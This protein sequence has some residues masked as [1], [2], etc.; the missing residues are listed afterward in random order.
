MGGSADS[1]TNRCPGCGL[2]LDDRDAPPP[3]RYNASGECWQL[4]GE[5]TADTISKGDP[6]FVHQHCVDAYGAQHS[7]GHTKPITTAFSLVGLYLFVERDYTGTQ[8]QRAHTT[9]GEQDRDWPELSPPPS[10]GETTV[11]TVVEADP[12]EERDRRIEEWAESVWQNW[13]HAHGWA[14]EVCSESLD[15]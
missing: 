7:G 8:V 13:D 9:L 6:G 14:R 12:G 5:L 15:I 4:Y 10:P 2:E 1:D 11:Q 3:D